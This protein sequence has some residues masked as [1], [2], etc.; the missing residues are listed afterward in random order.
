MEW[1]VMALAWPAILENI[2]TTLI[3]FVNVAMVGHLGAQATAAVGINTPLIW[4]LNSVMI[5]AGV[6]ATAVIARH[7]GAGEH[8]RANLAARQSVLLGLAL[9]LGL[10]AAVYLLSGVLPVWLGANPDIAPVAT[11]YLR[12][13][14]VTFPLYFLGLVLSAA[15]RGAGETRVPM[16][17]NVLINLVNVAGNF[18]L[19]HPTRVVHIGPDAAFTVWGAGLG[20]RGAAVSSAFAEGLAGMLLLAALASGR[21]TLR[22]RGGGP[23]RPD[24]AVLGKILH[25]GLP[26][27]GERCVISFGQMLFTR[28]IAVLGTAELAAHQL[29]NTAESLSY[30]PA[31]GIAVAATTLVGQGLGRKEPEQAARYGWASF[32]M[33]LVVMVSMMGVF[34]LVPHRLLG[35]FTTDAEV[36]RLGASVL[37]IEALAQP[38]FAAAIVL[39]GALRGAGDT[40]F[41]LLVAIFS[42]WGTRI[43][44]AWLLVTQCG[45]GLR[46]AWIAMVADL[47]VRGTLILIRFRRGA[48]KRVEV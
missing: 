40:R 22:L 28:L 14:A 34:L 9:G 16:R 8:A 45:M 30:M 37:R 13:L 25:V 1:T 27:A 39:T 24:F 5:A 48:W 38:F 6:G 2:L 41:P 47:A 20:V 10:T 11:G 23:F 46:G 35:L 7:M 36:I 44:M 42:M 31:Y 26:A 12:I 33:A 17:V 21:F 4:L 29:A 15:F 43:T 19:I 18:L 3:Q 32:R